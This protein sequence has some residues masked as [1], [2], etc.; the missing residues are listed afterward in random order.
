[1]PDIS[2][3]KGGDCPLKD[4]CYRYTV[5]PS[6]YQS[7]LYSLPYKVVNN[8]LMCEYFYRNHESK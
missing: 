2:K 7:Y 1:M 5:I 3:C 6:D 8:H 4:S